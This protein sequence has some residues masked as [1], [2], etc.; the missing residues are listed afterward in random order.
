MISVTTFPEMNTLFL[1]TNEF[2]CSKTLEPYLE[3]EIPHLAKAFQKVIIIPATI[4]TVQKSIPSNV[5]VINIFDK[6]LFKSDPITMLICLPSFVQFYLSELFDKNSRS[7]LYI[8]N[9]IKDYKSFYNAIVTGKAIQ[10]FSKLN[11]IDLKQSAFYS[12]W[13]FHPVLTL[14]ILKKK[15]II[16]SFISRGHLGDIYLDQFPELSNF[17]NYKIKNVSKLLLISTHAKNYV[18]KLYPA[19]QNKFVVSRLAVSDMGI[20]PKP[21]DEFVLVSCS[22]YSSRKRVDLLAKLL[23]N[24]PFPIT[25][26]HFGYVPNDVL[27]RFDDDFSKAKTPIKAIYKGDVPNNLV[28]D[29]YKSNAVNVIVNLSTSEGLPFSLIEATS[30]G[31]PTIATDVNGTPDIATTKNGFLMPQQF[32][33]TLFYNC[34][35]KI[36]ENSEMYR[37]GARELFEEKYNSQIN[38]EEVISC[39][40]Q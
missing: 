16:N 29:F 9:W 5:E 7:K 35:L 30:F 14:S 27:K 3:H 32:E 17:F 1:F 10:R 24:A 31:I 28:M 40:K 38:Y 20:N 19:L 4:N 11:K 8:K 26:C 18:G 22:T 37:K 33:S 34:L 6:Q 15:K 12:Y 13:F 25:W 2:P 21:Q 36:K 23:C 39:L